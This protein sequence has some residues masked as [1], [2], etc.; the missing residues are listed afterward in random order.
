ME[1][2]T[3]DSIEPDLRLV[4]L[5]T[6]LFYLEQGAKRCRVIRLMGS[7]EQPAP[8]I[9]RAGAAADIS[10]IDLIDRRVTDPAK[11]YTEK[12]PKPEWVVHR[13]NC[14]FPISD[15]KKETA[16]YMPRH[17]KLEVPIGGFKKRTQAMALWFQYGV[18]GVPKFPPRKREKRG[19]PEQVFQ[20][21]GVSV[22][23]R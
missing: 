23:V 7:P 17:I 2:W 1:Q 10:V 8:P 13:L 18:S 6:S 14:V 4:I 11:L 21:L 20:S 5:A 16:T 12:Y 9:Y 19:R 15:G 3:S 22:S